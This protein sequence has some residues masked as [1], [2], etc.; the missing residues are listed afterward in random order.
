MVP[1]KDVTLLVVMVG[2]TDYWP[3][4]RPFIANYCQR[5][6]YCFRVVSE[7]CM[8][9]EHHPSWQKL[10]AASFVKTSHAL[11]W[12]ADLV[13]L[14]WSPPIHLELSDSNIGMVRIEPS[15]VGRSKLRA[16]YGRKAAPLLTFNCGLISVPHRWRSL[17]REVFFSADYDQSIFWEQGAIN[18]EIHRCGIRVQELDRQWNCWVSGKISDEDLENA[19]CLHFAKGSRRRMQNIGR[20]YKML[21]LSDRLPEWA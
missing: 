19:N 2:Q 10:L 17:L 16:R 20:M 21:R 11:L 1:A 4:T 18:Y 13:P 9:T 12:D 6:G 15:K 8:A 7:D 14:P 3:Y 5:H